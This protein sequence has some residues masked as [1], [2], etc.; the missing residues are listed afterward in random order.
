MSP[1]AALIVC[2]AGIGGLFYLDRDKS[3]RTSKALW[4][5]VIW[6]WILGSRP[7]SVW[8]GLNPA[9][10]DPAA[11]L[12]GSPF[13]AGVF[14]AL[15]AVGIIVLISRKRRTSSCL[16]ASLPVIVYFGYCLL[17]VCWSDFPDVA[18]KRWIKA[19]GDLVMVLIVVTDAEPVAALRRLFSRVGFILLPISVVLIKY[20]GDLGRGYD[21]D[22]R[23][24]NTGVT[25]NKNTLGVITICYLARRVVGFPYFPRGQ[26]PA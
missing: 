12:E 22:G 9:T 2:I 15:L 14:A 17:S 6:L 26:G 11:V 8:L 4:L 21:P 1:S 16:K 5:P 19:I 25:T 10:A 3:L 18:F 24:M 13:D 7:V 23:P 20:Y